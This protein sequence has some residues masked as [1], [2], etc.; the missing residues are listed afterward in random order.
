[1][2]TKTQHRT[3][4]GPNIKALRYVRRLA[5]RPEVRRSQRLDF[6]LHVAFQLDS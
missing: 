3:F 2:L 5:R 4:I 1:M 6:K